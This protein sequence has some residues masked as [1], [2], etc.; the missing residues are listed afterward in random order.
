MLFMT[1]AF[2]YGLFP[3]I[4]SKYLYIP[5]SYLTFSLP[6]GLGL[7]CLRLRLPILLSYINSLH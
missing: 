4:I 7:F 5:F 3:I 6:L 1:N 2:R